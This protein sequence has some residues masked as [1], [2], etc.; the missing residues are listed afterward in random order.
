M[1]NNIINAILN[2]NKLIH[3]FGRCKQKLC[4]LSGDRFVKRLAFY[5]VMP[6]ELIQFIFKLITSDLYL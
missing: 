6:Q 5:N 2:D 1:A 4:Q 3:I